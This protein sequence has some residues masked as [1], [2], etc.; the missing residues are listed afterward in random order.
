LKAGD[1]NK[2]IDRQG[3]PAESESEII[4]MP[5]FEL[6]YDFESGS[7]VYLGIPFEDEPR[8]TIGY[9]QRLQNIGSFDISA[10]YGLPEKV[11]EDPYLT[12]IDRQKTD[13]TS[14]GGKIEHENEF[15]TVGYELELID[16]EKDNSGQRIEDLKRDGRVHRLGVEA[17]IHIGHKIMLESGIDYARAEFDGRSNRYNGYQGGLSVAK[18]WDSF[19]LHL[20]VEGGL[21]AFDAS[22]PIFD[23]TREDKVYEAIGF[24]SWLNPLGY[25]NFYLNVGGGYE[26]NDSNIAFYDSEA[27]FMFMTVG[28]QFGAGGIDDDD[29]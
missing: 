10:F 24:L 16:I 20:S 11:W 27:S 25:Q 13:K 4:L 21:N 12:N 19:M 17:E 2:R 5:F 7:N 15:I 29:D 26:K 3:S 23:K 22:H 18:M 1:R 28:Y 14:Y 6:N 9:K 8:P